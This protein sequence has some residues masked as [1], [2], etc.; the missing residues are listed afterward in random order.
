[1]SAAFERVLRA[2]P[3]AR[4]CG[5]RSGACNCG[6]KRPMSG[7]TVESLTELQNEMRLHLSLKAVV[8][9]LGGDTQGYNIALN[10]L[11]GRTPAHA[12]AVLER[13]AR[14]GVPVIQ[15]DDDVGEGW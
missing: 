13:M 10:A 5:C 11:L 12:L 4:F 9:Q 7:W 6:L 1:M 3:I 15:F 14:H 2:A 8:E